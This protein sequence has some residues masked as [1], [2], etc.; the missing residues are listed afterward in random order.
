MLP[1]E[2]GPDD[3]VDFRGPHGGLLQRRA[4]M[5]PFVNNI[6]VTQQVSSANGFRLNGK[7]SELETKILF[8]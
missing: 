3:V 2:G 1:P 5:R 8:Y 4:R 6:L 7:Y